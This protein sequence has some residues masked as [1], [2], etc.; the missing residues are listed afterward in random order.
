[1]KKFLCIFLCFVICFTDVW[2]DDF[3]TTIDVGY[4]EARKALSEGKYDEARLS[5]LKLLDF[6]LPRN[7][8]VNV[9]NELGVCYKNLGEY[10]KAE[11][12]L[13]ESL[14]LARARNKNAIRINLSNLYLISGGYQK[15]IDCLNQIDEERYFYDKLLNLS[16]AYFRRNEG[17]DINIAIN[18]IDSCLEKVD[19]ATNKPSYYLALQ[20]RGY[21]Y[22]NLDSLNNANDDLETALEVMPSDRALYY[23]TLANLAM[24]K[25]SLSDFSSA[26]SHIENVLSWQKMNIG[27]NHPDYIISLRKKA[28]ILLKMKQMRKAKDAFKEYYEAEK[29][30]VLKTFPSLS[31]QRR[32][33]FWASKKPLLSEVFQLGNTDADFLYDVALLRRHIALL[34][35]NEVQSLFK[36]FS[37]TSSN[38]RKSLSP[39]DVAI[40]FICYHDNERKDTVYAALLMSRNAPTKHIHLFTKDEFHGYKF[41]SSLDLETCVCAAADRNKNYIYKDTALAEKIWNPILKEIPQTINRIYFAADGLLQMLA[42]EYLP[43]PDL[44]SLVMSR[45]TSTANI[46]MKG[47]KRKHNE[48]LVIGGVVY[49]EHFATND[50]LAEMNHAAYDYFI[51]QCGGIGFGHLQGTV[52]EVDSIRQIV[53]M[54]D[55]GNPICTTES[56]L[57]QNMGDYAIVHLATH[58]YSLNVMVQNPP[59]SM[60]DSLMADNSLLASGI[61]LAGANVAGSENVAE[62]GLLS[63]RE[64]CEL[65]LSNVD[66]VILSACQTAQGYVSDEGPAG[67]VRGLKKAGVKTVIAT[68]WEVNDEATKIFMNAFYKAWV[69]LGKTKSEA[70][71]IAQQT[72]RNYTRTTRERRV[73]SLISHGKNNVGTSDLKPYSQPRYWAPFILVDDI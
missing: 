1:M 20:N 44:K 55:G 49:D 19:T 26:L 57:K 16:H 59:L 23:T 29:S 28:E 53:S 63:S 43:H 4:R 51:E 45:L 36:K 65:N 17:D 12:C 66:L 71:G 35:K 13:E 14:T 25:A 48:S 15:A 60:R 9:L 30:F 5:Y 54:A 7:S 41:N 47:H 2:A 11:K 32:L 69:L 58:G 68:L 46:C 52:V 10:V 3:D 72:V 8:R 6:N 42:I 64:L 62:D 34:G 31:E 27:E 61:V 67:V 18:L 24:I 56:F 38:V 21:I 22:W 37:I 40:E 73:K 70:L 39:S 33:D 50:T